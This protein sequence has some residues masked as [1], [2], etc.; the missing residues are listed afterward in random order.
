MI[1]TVLSWEDTFR[2]II[3]YLS[4]LLY[5]LLQYIFFAGKQTVRMDTSASVGASNERMD[6]VR[7]AL[8]EQLDKA[9]LPLHQANR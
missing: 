6:G 3:A 2:S 4:F 1:K 5:R 9:K 7:T 8:A